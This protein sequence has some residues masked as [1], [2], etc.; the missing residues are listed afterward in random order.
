MRKAYRKKL[1]EKLI[2]EN[3]ELYTAEKQIVD[4]DLKARSTESEFDANGYLFIQGYEPAIDKFKASSSVE[5]GGALRNLSSHRSSIEH[6]MPMGFKEQ[7]AAVRVQSVLRTFLVQRRMRDHARLIL[8]RY[9]AEQKKAVNQSSGSGSARGDGLPSSRRQT[10][11]R[12]PICSTKRD[13]K[14][15]FESSANLSA[16]LN[17]Y[18]S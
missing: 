3:E 11:F 18:H 16:H 6:D 9:Q 2:R 17:F 4:L 13:C 10:V 14:L 12:C 5:V 7:V 1:I 8:K 15:F